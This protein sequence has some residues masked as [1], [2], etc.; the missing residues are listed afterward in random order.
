MMLFSTKEFIE[1][2]D[3]ATY[4]RAIDLPVEFS[5]PSNIE[6]VFLDFLV[7]IHVKQEG[8]LIISSE[9]GF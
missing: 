6:K 9:L 5:E 8:K 3:G 7:Y 2:A 1:K 4:V